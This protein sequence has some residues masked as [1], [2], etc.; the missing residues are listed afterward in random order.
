[1]RKVHAIVVGLGTLLT[2]S[3]ALAQEQPAAGGQVEGTL[4]KPNVTVAAHPAKAEEAK[5]DGLTDHERVVGKFGVMF[6]GVSQQPIGGIANGATNAGAVTQS[7]VTGGVPVIGARY[8]LQEKMGIDVGVGLNFFSSSTDTKNNS[9]DVSSDGPAVVSFALHGGV[10]LAFAQGKHYTFLVVPELNFGYATQTIAAQNVP[11]GQV[12]PANFHL[13]GWRLDAGARIG[14]EIQFGF[15][16][17]PQ[18]SLQASIGLNFRHQNWAAS[19]DS[20]P[21]ATPASTSSSRSANNFGTTVQ[22]DP[23]AIFVNN[24]S[25]IYYFP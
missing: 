15:I 6:F 17:V 13:S 3:T 7:T 21:P 10:P 16:G 9:T 8:W 14:S 22:S 19:Q 20:A 12:A 2:A 24:I 25:A 4:P 18:L 23:W 1:M 11:A 5:E